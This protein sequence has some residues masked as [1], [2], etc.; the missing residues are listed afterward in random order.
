MLSANV[1]PDRHVL[2]A[3]SLEYIASIPSITARLLLTLVPPDAAF[4]LP[5]SLQEVRYNASAK[6][7]AREARIP[8][9]N[10]RINCWHV[11]RDS[12]R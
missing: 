10:T 5:L 3:A 9:V 6:T 8:L 11:R 4:F 7:S 12:S 1:S 2:G